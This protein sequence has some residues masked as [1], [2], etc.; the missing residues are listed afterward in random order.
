MTEAEHI[1]LREA[2]EQLLR[3]NAQHRQGFIERVV[4]DPKATVEPM[5]AS[6]VGDDGDL[7]LSAVDVRVHIATPGTIHL[8]LD[9]TELGTDAAVPEVAGH[10]FRSSVGSLGI[11]LRMPV[12]RPKS[13]FDDSSS[14][15]AC[16][17]SDM[18]CHSNVDWTN[19]CGGCTS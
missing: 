18:S 4:L 7:D 10:A 12:R 2:L 14:G 3:D 6:L 8:V 11:D 15:V 5:I 1:S 13:V 17:G 19:Y 9:A 16:S